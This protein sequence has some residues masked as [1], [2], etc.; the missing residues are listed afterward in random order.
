M[1]NW[2]DRLIRIQ[3]SDSTVNEIMEVYREAAEVHEQALISMGQQPTAT[4]STFSSTKIVSL[5]PGLNSRGDH[6]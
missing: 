5:I 1:E 2:T 4:R 3:E 6:Q